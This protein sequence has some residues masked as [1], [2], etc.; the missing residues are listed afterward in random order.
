MLVR[1]LTLALLLAT[2]TTVACERER[3]TQGVQRPS[4]ARSEEP[5]ADRETAASRPGIT[6][7]R[8]VGE[9]VSSPVAYAALTIDADGT[10]EAFSMPYSVDGCGTVVGNGTSRGTWHLDGGAVRFSPIDEPLDLAI[11][12][13]GVW[14]L[15]EGADLKFRSAGWDVVLQRSAAKSSGAE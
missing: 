11:S 4:A 6:L 5:V 12:L 7:E 15:P 10:Y 14:A 9:W 1:A 3:A 8:L 13:N 2:L